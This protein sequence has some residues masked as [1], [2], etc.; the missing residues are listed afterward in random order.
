MREYALQI[1]IRQGTEEDFPLIYNT[2]SRCY[3]EDLLQQLEGDR[4][5]IQGYQYFRLDPN[6]FAIAQNCIME[7]IINNNRILMAVDPKHP[8][9]A[10][11]YIIYNDNP[12]TLHWIY[13]KYNF[14]NAGVGNRLMVAAFN[15][16][17]SPIEYTL[18]TAAI[19]HH[20]ERWNLVF[21][22]ESLND[23]EQDR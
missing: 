9:Q 8:D 4:K 12:R 20:I 22:S 21:N 3:Y 17:M 2:W 7:K 14:R 15:D 6:W 16:F 23:K 13:T 19:K 11:G 5:R 18:K 1:A 10:Y